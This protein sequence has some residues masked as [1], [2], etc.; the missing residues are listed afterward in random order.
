[1]SHEEYWARRLTGFIDAPADA[2]YEFALTSDDGS[3]LWIDG[4]LVVDNDGLHGSVTKIGH[5][6]LA[7]GAHKI[8]VSWFNKSG[9]LDLALQWAKVGDKL[10]PA[11]ELSH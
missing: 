5:V 8:V 4:E 11:S 2:V 1:M 6:A 7:K 3:K 9:N 10:K